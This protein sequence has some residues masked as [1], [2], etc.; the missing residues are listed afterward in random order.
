MFKILRKARKK[1]RTSVPILK[2]GYLS[3]VFTFFLFFFNIYL[4]L[5]LLAGWV[6]VAARGLSL[7][8]YWLLV[9]MI[10]LIEKH[11]L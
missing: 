9:A 11:R 6:F 2:I 5:Y 1:K 7:A 3:F 10:S 8:G 4:L